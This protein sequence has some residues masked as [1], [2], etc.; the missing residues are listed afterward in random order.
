MYAARGLPGR[1]PAMGPSQPDTHT[2][3]RRDPS[4]RPDYRRA[5]TR[6]KDAYGARS[7]DPGLPRAQTGSDAGKGH[8]RSAHHALQ[9]AQRH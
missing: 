2:Q 1:K 5:L 6:V 4:R 8:T 3:P 9:T 7:F